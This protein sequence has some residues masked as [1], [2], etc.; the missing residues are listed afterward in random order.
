VHG[1]SRPLFA[2]LCHSLPLSAISSL[3]TLPFSATATTIWLSLKLCATLCQAC[4]SCHSA[5]LCAILCHSAPLSATLC[6]SLPLSATVTA[7]HSLALSLKLSAT[8]CQACYSRHSR[9]S[10]PLSA[11]ASHSLALSLSEALCYSATL[12]LSTL[13]CACCYARPL[14]L[15][16]LPLSLPLVVSLYRLFLIAAPMISGH[17]LAGRAASSAICCQQFYVLIQPSRFRRRVP[18]IPPRYQ[19]RSHRNLLSV[20]L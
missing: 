11:T 20:C 9:H 16:S 13:S 1:H 8:L 3:P 17:C 10:A 18:S 14:C 6:H 4:Y 2:T 12:L 7:S 5:P 15:S 19:G